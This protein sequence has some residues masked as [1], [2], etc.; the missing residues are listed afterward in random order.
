MTTIYKYSV[1]VK[2]SEMLDFPKGSI[3]LSVHNQ[4][5]ALVIYALVDTSET[6]LEAYIINT[7]ETGQQIP[8][9]FIIGHFLGTVMFD[10][11][12][13]VTHVFYNKLETDIITVTQE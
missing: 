7:V 11:G 10:S 12:K 1:I 6:E 8:E 4:N 2:G 3:L 9:G 5:G 13:Y